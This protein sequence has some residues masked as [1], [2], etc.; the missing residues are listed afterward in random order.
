MGGAGKPASGVLV[1][2]DIRDLKRLATQLEGW[3]ATKMPQASEI[4]ITDLSYP[5]GAGQSHET[6][7]FDAAWR[8]GTVRHHE[9][10]VVRIKPTRFK[11]FLDDMFV[12]QYRLMRVVHESGVVPVAE[13]LWFEE[14]PSLL[15]APFFVMRKVAGRVAVSVPSYLDVGWVAEATKQQ[16]ET[17]W[18]NSVRTLAATQRIP[19]SSVQFLERPG[20]GD[21]FEQE[22]DRWRRFL[23]FLQARH[24]MPALE[25]IWRRL[26]DAR[27]GNRPP[28]LVWGDARL[29]NMMVGDDFSIVAVMDWEQTSLGGALHDLAWWILMER[30]KVQARGAPLPGLGDRDDTIALWHS[31]T[32]ISVADIDWY[33]AFVAFKTCCLST[34][35]LDMRG[36]T[37]PGGDYGA[38]PA[39]LQA[40][41]LLDA[42]GA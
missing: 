19:L 14:D 10:L 23:E 6:I 1:A 9:G 36:G 25:A 13:P 20:V 38:M 35:M 2:P 24:P 26:E 34:N 28:G 39:L 37:P 3:L 22:W 41:R 33:E 8:E 31:E 18:L 15:G 17:L 30:S 29:G 27:P 11:V 40:R 5:F 12:E 4:R 42:I 21:G 32:G 7:L 16:R